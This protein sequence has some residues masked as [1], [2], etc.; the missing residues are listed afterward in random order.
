MISENQNAL[1]KPSNLS[2]AWGFAAMDLQPVSVAGK[3]Y[4]YMAAAKCMNF[5]C[6]L[7]ASGGW[8]FLRCQKRKKTPKKKIN[9]FYMVCNLFDTLRIEYGTGIMRI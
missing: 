8:R 4:M 3:H 9:S 1:L 7:S 5:H 6:P 2:H